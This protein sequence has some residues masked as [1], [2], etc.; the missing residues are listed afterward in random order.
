M[1]ITYLGATAILVLF[2]LPSSSCP[3]GPEEE[4]GVA[5]PASRFATG[6]TA[7]IRCTPNAPRRGGV[8]FSWTPAR[9]TPEAQRVEYT[10]AVEGFETGDFSISPELPPDATTWQ[11]DPTTPDT[12]YRWRV[13]G[14]YAD[15]WVAGPPS[16]FH[17]A[18]CA[19]DIQFFVSDDPKTAASDLSATAD[20]D[21]ENLGVGVAKLAWQPAE[22]G[23]EQRIVMGALPNVFETFLFDVSPP[24]EPDRTE[25]DWRPLAGRATHYWRVLTRAPR[26][27]VSSPTATVQG[28]P[29]IADEVG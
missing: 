16:Q 25:F 27:W 19:G 15:A 24:L 22:A 7:S 5:Q 14:R 4:Q 29:C 17:S 20:C 9:A 10:T 13:A 11:L 1:P 18:L 2:A 3:A 8:D 28:V 21:P 26:G 6:L 12:D 23:G